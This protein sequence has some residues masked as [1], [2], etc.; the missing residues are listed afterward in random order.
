MPT[1]AHPGCSKSVNIMAF[2]CK[3]GGVFCSKHRLPSDHA[4]KY[5]FKAEGRKKLAEENPK[6]VCE[7][8]C[9]V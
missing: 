4:C 8:V 6:V 1:C 3:C 5:D 7:K 2:R 9:Q